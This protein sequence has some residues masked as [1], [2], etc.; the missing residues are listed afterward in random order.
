MWPSYHMDVIVFVII[1]LYKYSF[2]ERSNSSDL[3]LNNTE[4]L[5]GEH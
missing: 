3:A 2:Y 1:T 4:L 5:E